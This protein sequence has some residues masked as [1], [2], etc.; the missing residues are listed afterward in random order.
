[1]AWTKLGSLWKNESPTG[2]K[3]LSGVI[4]I[5]EKKTNISIWINDKGDNPK[6]PDFN[7]Y[8]IEKQKPVAPAEQ[9]D[10]DDDADAWEMPF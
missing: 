8:L 10:A 9:S 3:Y 2:K 4:E 1:M 5:D 7:I 6:R